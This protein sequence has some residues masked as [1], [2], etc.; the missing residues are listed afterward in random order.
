MPNTIASS[1]SGLNNT[2]VCKFLLPCG[3]CE[4]KR[5]QCSRRSNIIN[6]PRWDTTPI[7]TIDYEP[8]TVPGIAPDPLKTT[9]SWEVGDWPPG[10]QPTCRDLASDSD[11]FKVHFEDL[12]KYSTSDSSAYSC[13][14]T[15][16]NEK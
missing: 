10:P 15:A 4:L 16:K 12:P 13:A 6:I 8:L 3:Y 2:V 5:E 9:K 11:T 1:T 7:K 14:T